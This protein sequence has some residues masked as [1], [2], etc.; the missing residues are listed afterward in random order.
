MFDRAIRALTVMATSEKVL[1]CRITDAWSSIDA[2]S[3]TSGPNPLTGELG[4]WFESLNEKQNRPHGQER[5]LSKED[6]EK[7]IR[8]LVQLCVD[9]AQFAI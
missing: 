2:L 8:E 6:A 7:E 3:A 4:K 1:H 9:I 5:V